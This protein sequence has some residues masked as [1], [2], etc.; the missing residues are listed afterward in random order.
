VLVLDTILNVELLELAVDAAHQGHLVICAARGH[1]VA[2]AIGELVSISSPAERPRM[3]MA[4]SRALAG[5][6]ADAGPALSGGEP[7]ARELLV[8]SPES[9]YLIAEGRFAGLGHPDRRR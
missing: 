2:H 8:N 7:G 6:I 9:A 4:L 3:Q 1:G 5:V